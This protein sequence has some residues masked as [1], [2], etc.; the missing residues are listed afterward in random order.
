MK[1]RD[2]S[3][4]RLILASH[5]PRRKAFLKD[6]GFSFKIVP[7]HID[8]QPRPKEGPLAYVRRM[9]KEKAEKASRLFP[10]RWVLAADTVVVLGRKILGKPRSKGEA[11]RYL[12]L[13]SGKTHRVITAFCLKKGKKGLV[14]AVSSWVTFKELR[15]EEIRWYVRTG[16]PMDKAGAYAI[17]GKGAFCVKRIRGSYTNVVGL[18]LTEVLEALESQA[19]VRLN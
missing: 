14:K 9:A 3:P 7:V 10:D 19:G 15:P 11:E 1:K 4:E 2:Y 8:E 13:L 18:P 5:S 16:E 12:R 6:L 17:Q